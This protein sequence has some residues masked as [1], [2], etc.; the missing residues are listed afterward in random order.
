MSRHQQG[1]TYF[2]PSP[3]GSEVNDRLS[4]GAGHGNPARG[5]SYSALRIILAV[6]AI[7]F[8]AEVV[9]MLI[10]A[11][12]AIDSLVAEAF[13][14]AAML[15]TIIAPALYFIVF[16]PL[17]AL[18]R[19]HRHS[20]ESFRAIVDKSDDG[21]LLVGQSGIVR[22]AN[23][24]A[25]HLL[26]RKYEQLVCK[27]FGL[28]ISE[29]KTTEI[30]L[31]TGAGMT[32]TAEMR[33]LSTHW[34]NESCFLVTLRDVT[35]NANLREKL[36]EQS[37]H[38]ELTGLHNRRGFFTLSERPF[39]MAQRG[40]PRV[41]LCFI[42]LDGM[43]PINDVHGHDCGDL[44]LK[45]TAALLRDTFRETDIIARLGG[46][47]FAVLCL[48]PASTTEETSPIA[49]LQE[50]VADFNNAGHRPYQL[51][52]SMGTVDHDPSGS[53]SL[54][55]LLARADEHMYNHKQEKQ[56]ARDQQEARLAAA[57]VAHSKI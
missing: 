4:N 51:S 34:H 16:R 12:V 50:R 46:D 6:I 35:A 44:A 15:T 33:V 10:L 31:V 39:K 2:A 1:S 47:E 3:L 19:E 54:N 23:H 11:Q 20:K 53:A 56:T 52:F 41:R 18:I 45:D 5:T 30:D 14:D 57:A 36:R 13:A 49:R 42:D 17:L 26:N 48:S 43:K 37:L 7:A 38:D 21:I 28:P 27:N 29:D 8:A 55:E 40:G 25:T 9:V 24:A 32:V 22:F